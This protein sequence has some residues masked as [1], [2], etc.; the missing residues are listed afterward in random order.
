[1]KINLID[2]YLND[3]VIVVQPEIFKDNRGFFYE[4]FK[5]TELEKFGIP[6]DFVQENHSSSV[7][8]V[9]RGLHF[10]WEPQMGKLMRVTKGKAFLVAVDMRKN[11]PTL[12]KWI[13]IEASEE[14]R[15]LMWAPWYFAR[16]FAVI[17]DYA[18][19]QYLVTGEY[20]KDSESGILWNDPTIG[21]KWPINNPIVSDKDEKALTMQEWMNSKE[22]KLIMWN[23]K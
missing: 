14:N 10:Q 5:R 18:E 15:Y 21:I 9:V 4:V 22:S 1:M 3:E 8:N 6:A 17:S 2:K 16:G 23:N 12:G 11:S 20:N 13:G 19:I 7:K